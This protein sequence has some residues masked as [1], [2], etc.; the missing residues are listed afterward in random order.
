MVCRQST[1]YLGVHP[2]QEIFLYDVKSPKPQLIKKFT[3]VRQSRFSIRACFG[4]VKSNLVVSGSEGSFNW[5][6]TFNIC[7]SIIH[8]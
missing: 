4:G 7:V 6:T 5:R 1:P 8:Y 3:G 2:S